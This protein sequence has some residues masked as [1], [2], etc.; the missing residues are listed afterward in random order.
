MMALKQISLIAL[1]LALAACGTVNRGMESVHQP[2]VQRTDYVI[3]LATAGD[4]LAL[5]EQERLDGWFRS[6]G[7]A[8]GDRVAIDGPAGTARGDVAE[9]LARR[10]MSVSGTAP[11][12]AGQITPGS[13]RVIVS[14]SSAS[15]PGCPDW[16]RPSAPDFVG[17][18]MSNYGCANNAAL[19]AM[20]ADPMDLIRGRD[21][22]IA[23]D[24]AVS[25][26]AIDAYRTA[27]PTGTRGIKAESTSK[28]GK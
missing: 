5:G 27:P 15:V 25:S 7:L 19:A 6:I 11:V 13:V 3:D 26:K 28:V 9:L 24:P 20:V 23:V 2:I 10:G 8:Y 21:D 14:R 22:G 17:S 4:G 18:T 1:P 12:T 16:S